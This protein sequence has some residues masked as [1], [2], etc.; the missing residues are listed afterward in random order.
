MSN[1]ENHHNELRVHIAN[2]LD[3]FWR[4]RQRQ[5]DAGVVVRP[6]FRQP[7]G[8]VCSLGDGLKRP[9]EHLADEALGGLMR[10]LGEPSSVASNLAEGEQV[11]AFLNDAEAY[12]A[13]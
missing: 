11:K 5:G 12:H 6:R 8:H 10:A 4:A 13:A 7:R 3:D 9:T 2:Q 1:R